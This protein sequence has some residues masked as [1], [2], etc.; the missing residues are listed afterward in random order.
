MRIK[1]HLFLAAALLLAAAIALPAQ[2]G[3]G[4]GRL[5]GT[6]VDEDGAPL[7]N[8]TVTLKYMEFNNT[9][10][11]KSNAKGQWGF[12]ALGKGV[13]QVTGEME[14]YASSVTQ[15]PV[16]G[17]APNPEI[18]I[19]LKKG[20]GVAGDPNRDAILRAHEMF[21]KRQYEEALAL[22]QEFA[23]KNPANYQIGVY[24]AN[25]KTELGN[26]EEAM[27]EFQRVLA[28]VTKETPELKGNATAALVFAGIGDIHLRQENFK[29]AVEN[30]QRSIDIQPGDPALPY[31]VAE[32][33][34]A[35]A[36]VDEAE[37]YYRLAIQ[38]KPAWPKPYLKLAY[39]AMNRGEMDK[40]VEHLKKFVEIG[41]AEANFEEGKAL[42]DLLQKK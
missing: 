37:K 8:A 5:T 24:I 28:E 34:F 6:V 9:R 19:V 15:Q 17:V 33:M 36:K 42:L 39:V 12:L 22:Y 4:N 29:L 23:Q 32:I 3:R 30:F 31:N 11:T 7:A 27:A 20:S 16:S 25:C 41:A 2:E 13:V 35:R 18:R 40:A 26:Y 10:Q 14:G 38:I 21:D 1:T